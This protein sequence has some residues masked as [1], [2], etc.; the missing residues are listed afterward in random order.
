MNK[1]Q[2]IGRVTREIEL[3]KT[4]SGKSVISFSLA[5]NRRKKDEGADY[6]NCVAWEQTA[7]IMQKYV[8]KGDRISVSGRIQSRSYERDGK[9][10]YTTDIVVEE[11]E[12]L[13]NKKQSESPYTPNTNTVGDPA[14]G[15]TPSE[16]D[17]NIQHLIEDKEL[18]TAFEQSGNSAEG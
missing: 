16:E 3:K 6:I 7:E 12:F 9:K 4:Q 17:A 10:V 13:E 15:E 1:V 18:D 8:G 2:L 11:L 14:N 5:V